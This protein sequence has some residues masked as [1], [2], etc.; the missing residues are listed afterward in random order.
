M[1]SDSKGAILIETEEVEESQSTYVQVLK[2]P[3]RR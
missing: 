2:E 1:R 3:T